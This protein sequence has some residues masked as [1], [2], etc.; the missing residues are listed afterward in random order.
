MSQGCC[1]YCRATRPRL[2]VAR[3]MALVSGHK[4]TFESGLGPGA[5]QWL[6][7]EH[8]H[9]LSFRY[10][11]VNMGRDRKDC[12]VCG[13]K[14]LLRL[15]NHLRDMHGMYAGDSP[16][17]EEMV[18][19]EGSDDITD[20]EDTDVED[21]DV[22]E[23]ET[24]GDVTEDETEDDDDE[25]DD[26]ET[27]DDP[28]ANWVNTIFQQYQEPMVERVATL[29]ATGVESGDA[30]HRAFEEYLQP[31]NKELQK[32][33]VQFTNLSHLFKKDPTYKKIMDT[34]RRG[35]EQDEM[36][37]HESVT[38]ATDKRNLLLNRVLQAY[39]PDLSMDAEKEEV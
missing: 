3:E 2:K 8:L 21:T 25:T 6:N 24:D 17:D 30:Q 32:K 12:P 18:S 19:D 34:A 10:R 16:L 36:D 14:G 22:E 1:I 5:I 29:E 13:K 23:E 26:E 39:T 4:A 31:M 27:E 38:Y 7:H 35:R 15:P 37:W 11:G 20:V 28:W 33:F 9:Q